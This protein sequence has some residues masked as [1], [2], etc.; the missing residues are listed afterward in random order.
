VSEIS[1]IS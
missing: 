1:T